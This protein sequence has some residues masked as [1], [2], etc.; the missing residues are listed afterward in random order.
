[1]SST[2]INVRVS[3]DLKRAF[4]AKCDE[5]GKRYYEVT[6]ELMEAYIEGRVTIEPTPAQKKMIKETYNVN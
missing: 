2:N 1:M 4:K 5:H 3:F 6:R